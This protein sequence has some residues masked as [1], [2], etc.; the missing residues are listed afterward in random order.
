MRILYCNGLSHFLTKITVHLLYC[1]LTAKLISAFVFATQIVHFLYFLNPKFLASNH[2][3]DSTARFVSALVGIQ[4]VGF[5]THR[6]M[7]C[8]YAFGGFKWTEYA[9]CIL[10]YSSP[11]VPDGVQKYD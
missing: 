3:L 4:I 6:K 10:I 8:R 2:L 11:V 7:C 5:L 9:I 1:H